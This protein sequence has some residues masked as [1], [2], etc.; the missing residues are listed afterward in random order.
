MK[1]LITAL[2]FSLFLSISHALPSFSQHMGKRPGPGMGGRPWRGETPCWGALD[3][4]SSPDQLKGLEQ[5]HQAY[6]RETQLL[7]AEIFLKR[8]ELR[9]VLTSP[10]SKGES[11]LS[12]YSEMN[13]LQ[14]KLEEKS[15]E[16]LIKVRSLLTPEQLKDWCPER[17][18]P[19]FRR[20][21]GP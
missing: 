2:A 9:E 3:L 14:S 8:L 12:K 5:I 7:R 4:T 6:L 21:M 17:E 20:M 1:L 18:L 11:I 10:T 15:I 16:Y 13:Q 19:P